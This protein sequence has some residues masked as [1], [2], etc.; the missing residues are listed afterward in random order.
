M[1]LRGIHSTKLGYHEGNGTSTEGLR[2][3][4][5]SHNQ[6]SL[7]AILRVVFVS[8]FFVV[9]S[10]LFPLLSYF[11][12]WDKIEIKIEKNILRFLLSFLLQLFF[13]LWTSRR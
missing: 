6:N 12:F 11:C 13:R 8:N 1:T 7:C 3:A 2:E 4:C 10:F 5:F 9:F